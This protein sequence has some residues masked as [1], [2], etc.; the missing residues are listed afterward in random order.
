MLSGLNKSIAKK[1][2]I[3]KENIEKKIAS[4][5]NNLRKRTY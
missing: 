1:K 4:L 2:N 3:K 5:L